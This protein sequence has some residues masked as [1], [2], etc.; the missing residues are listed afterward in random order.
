[1]HVNQTAS[2]QSHVNVIRRLSCF[3]FSA[4]EG[5]PTQ[6]HTNSSKQVANPAFVH[7]TPEQQPWFDIVTRPLD[8]PSHL[9]RREHSG[10]DA[11]YT[12]PHIVPRSLAHPDHT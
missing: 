12:T 2:V 8:L 6:L 11:L 9:V 1:M 3:L 4:H 10:T 5:A 7:P